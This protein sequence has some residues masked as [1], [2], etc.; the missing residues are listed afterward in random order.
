MEQGRA[1]RSLLKDTADKSR[2]C[3]FGVPSIELCARQVAKTKVNKQH[4]SPSTRNS[5]LLP[6]SCLSLQ[7]NTWSA[8]AAGRH[9]GS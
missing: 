3:S 8:L 9:A 5:V 7:D 4:R 6:K 1:E 2:R